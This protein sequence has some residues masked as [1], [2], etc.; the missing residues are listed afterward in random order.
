MDLTLRPKQTQTLS[1]QMVQSMNLL[2]MD[3]MELRDYLQEQFQENPA[4]ELEPPVRP[5]EGDRDSGG[6]ALLQKLE[7]LHTSDVQNSWYN[8]EDARE[9]GGRFPEPPDAASGGESLYAHLHAQLPELPSALSAAAE[10]V[11]KSLDSAGRLEDSPEALA[12]HAGLPA[13]VVEEAVRLVQGLDP[14]GVAARDLSQCLCL[15]LI[16]RGETGLPLRIAQSYLEDMGQDHYHRIAQATGAGREEVQAA[17]RLI[18]SLDPRPGAAFGPE[19]P[20][21]YV[22]PDLAVVAEAGRLE[23]VLNDAFLP[24]LRVSSY[25]YQ[26]MK[27]TDDAQVRDYLSQ[28]VHQARWL[29]RSI[30]QRQ[31]TLLS[32][33]R[34]IVAW[35]VSFFRLG[36]DHLRPMSL[37]DIAGQLD[38]HGSTV[39]RA[40][41]GKYLQCAFGVYP[42]KHFFGGALPG[43]G[44]ADG[45][46]AQRAKCALR[47]LIDGEDKRT[48]LSDQKLC[49]LLAARGVELSRRTVA[50]YRDELGIP[51]TFGRKQL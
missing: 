42:L 22:I 9:A 50:K 31:S 10:L 8:R 32:C 28:K 46:S 2:Q 30:E 15:Q 33:A 7:W 17:C 40:V 6:D 45:V 18:R 39:S 27:H 12:A 29:L 23:V 24:T 36:P 4:L 25:Y 51:S 16:R 37:A 5:A 41:R 11:L 19:G 43:A 1:P 26:L 38:I 49:Q 14:A 44:G 20:A 48:P 35:Q 34:C 3:A 21:Q 47:A 13:A